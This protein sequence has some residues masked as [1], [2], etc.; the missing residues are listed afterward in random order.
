MISTNALSVFI[1]HHHLNGLGNKNLRSIK[2]F[3][4]ARET[5]AK[6]YKR[7]CKDFPNLAILTES[8]TPGKV[9]LTFGHAAVGNNS[10]WGYAVSFILAGYLSSPFVIS[11]KIEI[12][13]AADG[14]K[15]CLPIAEV[16]LRSAAGNLARM[17]NQ[18]DWM[19]R[20]AVLLP[21]FLTEA[22]IPHGESDAGELLKIFACSITEWEKEGETASEV[23]DGNNE[24]SVITIDA[25]DEK[26][27]KPGKVKQAT[28]ETLTTIPYN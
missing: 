27:E 13:F 7:V 28:A 17:K 9:Q 10:L 12:V 4:R 18:M 3:I 26:T 22:A 25:E 21:P 14:N 19:P 15:I 11:T 24:D 23:D 8:A 5:A 6:K 1:L 16:L 20:N 2:D